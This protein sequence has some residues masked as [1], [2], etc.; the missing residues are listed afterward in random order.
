MAAKTGL[1]G[2]VLRGARHSQCIQVRLQSGRR[3]HTHAQRGLSQGVS[4][5]PASTGSLQKVWGTHGWDVPMGK[6]F[7]GNRLRRMPI[8]EGLYGLC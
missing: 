5:L 8:A 6:D 2:A 7:C 1:A 4:K 3:W